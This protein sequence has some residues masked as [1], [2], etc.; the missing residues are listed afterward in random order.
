MDLN[1]LINEFSN[2]ATQ[3]RLILTADELTAYKD[4]LKG[5]GM[6]DNDIDDTFIHVV[7]PKFP[8][9]AYL[10][11]RINDLK[12]LLT[13]IGFLNASELTYGSTPLNGIFYDNY[14]FVVNENGNVRFRTREEKQTMDQEKRR[15][16]EGNTGG[17]Y[18]KS[19]KSRK[20]RKQRKTKSKSRR[21]RR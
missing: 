6:S 8:N 12:L 7:V 16:K 4:E 19:K 18:K 14:Y 3:G 11:S 9:G 5:S 13:R 15:K 2:E 20:Q 1:D 21:S 10:P 17:F